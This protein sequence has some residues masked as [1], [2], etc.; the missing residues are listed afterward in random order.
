MP[1]FPLLTLGTIAA[2]TL[3][4]AAVAFSLKNILHCL[5]LLVVSWVG[6]AAFYLWAGAEF[7]AFAQVLVYVGAIS[8]VVLFAVLLTRQHQPEE[9]PP[10][11]AFRAWGA[12]T[13]AL[14][15][16]I[17]CAAVAATPLADNSSGSA[18]LSVRQ[19][20]ELLMGPHVAAL[21][22]IGVLLTVALLGAVL[23][24]APD[25]PKEKLPAET[26]K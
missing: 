20:G 9:N 11:R 18:A 23:L 2:V 26:K 10:A 7:I 13:A 12:L 15:A 1:D 5:L 4:S 14:V 19:T 3:V 21:L 16:T 6:V 17:L 22:I 24:A 8:M 25:S